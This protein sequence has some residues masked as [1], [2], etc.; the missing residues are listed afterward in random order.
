LI[1]AIIACSQNQ[2]YE[3]PP[4]LKNLISLLGALLIIF[5]VALLDGSKFF[6]GWW[7]LMP[8]VGSALIIF[9]GS[10][11]W[12]N[13]V[14]LS[15][16]VLVWIGLISFPFYLLHWLFFSFYGIVYIDKRSNLTS[17][18]LLL[19]SLFFAWILYKFIESPIRR[20]GKNKTTITL[21]FLMAVIGFI[22]YNTY[23]R[24]GLPHR[25]AAINNISPD[26][27]GY[28]STVPDCSIGEPNFPI[29]KLPAECFSAKRSDGNTVSVFLWGD[30]HVANLSW[31]LSSQKIQDY[32]IDLRYLTKGQCPPAP[33]FR[34]T[35][36][37]L[38]DQF[39][40]YAIDEIR[41]YQPNTVILL[42]DW[43]IY[44]GTDPANHLSNQKI[45][46]T[47]SQ[48]KSIGIKRIVLVGNFPDFE[49]NQAKIGYELFRPNSKIRTYKRFDFQTLKADK[50]I[51]TLASEMGVNF[52]SPLQLLCN[53]E[54]CLISASQEK[55][56]PMAYDKTHLTFQGSEY[57]VRNFIDKNFFR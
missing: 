22:G 13:K 12:L 35:P 56:I 53:Q 17:F 39:Y 34:P 54:G 43:V 47:I 15:S 55:F 29:F 30:S 4:F 50:R 2:G 44:K 6:P 38:C 24:G 20:Y 51:E 36:N 10:S 7:A 26:L 11:A 23:V 3:T 27:L 45:S 48:L 37:I 46:S 5:A 19:L 33:D 40:N 8:T 32:D 14:F 41:K 16:K 25:V 9:S 57:F 21:L 31:G 28:D 1:G 52:I 49:I 18:S 42:A